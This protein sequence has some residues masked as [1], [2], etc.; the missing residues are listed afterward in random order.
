MPYKI[1]ME[2]L[3]DDIDLWKYMDVSKF[4]SLLSTGE[5]W[6]AR[7]NTLKDKR[8]GYFSKEMKDE[9]NV[10]YEQLK[11]ENK[12]TSDSQI[13]NAFD[14]EEYV[15]NNSYFTC[16]HKNADENMIMWEIYGESENSV[17]L[18]T[19]SSKLKSC[20]NLDDVMKFSLEIALDDVQ[21]LDFDSLPSLQCSRQPFFIKRPHFSFEKEVR[22]YIKSREHHYSEGCPP[23]YKI[24]VDLNVLIEE[25]YVHPDAEQWF[26]EAIIDVVKKYKLSAPV[27]RGVC[28]NQF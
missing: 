24:S 10:I 18:K 15:K 3:E 20:F 7:S 16:W 6:L 21:Y 28:G 13:K 9:L 25:V 2:Y 27:T 1:I 26:F 4:L 22:L 11:F 14:Y 5:L 23:G 19:N 17:A 12:I 8:E